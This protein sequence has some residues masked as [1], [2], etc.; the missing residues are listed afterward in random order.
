[1]FRL[2][3]RVDDGFFN[4]PVEPMFA[5]SARCGPL[6]RSVQS[7]RHWTPSYSVSGSNTP[8]RLPSDP[9]RRMVWQRAAFREWLDAMPTVWRCFFIGTIRFV[10]AS[11]TPQLCSRSRRISRIRQTASPASSGP[12]PDLVDPLASYE[13]SQLHASSNKMTPRGTAANTFV[14]SLEHRRLAGW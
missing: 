6:R 3:I 14:D 9:V 11:R 8:L 4:E 1:M 5:E 13:A 2:T 10:L 12:E 7:W